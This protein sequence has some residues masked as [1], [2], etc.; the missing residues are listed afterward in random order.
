[1]S[2]RGESMW[3]QQNEAS[4]SRIGCAALIETRGVHQPPNIE[5]IRI[6]DHFTPH[7]EAHEGALGM[8]LTNIPLGEIT[9]DHFQRLIAAQAA[10][11][12]HVEYKRETYGTN[13]DQ[14]REYLAD[15]SSFANSAGGDLVI[16]MIAAKGTPTRVHRF[17]GD[18]D[19]E[20]LR[21]EQMARDGL[22]PRITNLQTRAVGLSGGGF[23]IVVRVPKSYNPPHRI[24]FKNNARFWARSSAGKYE[25]NVE[26]LRRIFSEIPLLA[27]RVRAFRTERTARIAAH[28]TPVG[29]LDGGNLVLHVVPFAAFDFGQSLSLDR[30]AAQPHLFVPIDSRAAQN[31]QIT[32]DGLIT[33]S[34]AEGLS[35]P[36]R[37]YVQ[38][39]RSSAVEAVASSLSRGEETLILPHIEAM[40]VKY[41]RSYAVSLQK[42][43]AE[44]PFAILVSLV[45]IKGK[46]ILQGVSNDP[47][48]GSAVLNHDQYNFV[49]TIFENVPL[50]NNDAAKQLRATLDHLAN[51]AGLPSSPYF[52][53]NG[54]YHI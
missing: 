28:E 15:V 50:D 22:H 29:L 5:A 6:D 46:R 37:A 43:G 48:F 32:F 10:E 1:M 21:L 31:Y 25:P 24:I 13:D 30:V 12:L 9:E 17:E 41:S 45:D 54:D 53:D 18:A 19:A 23:V 8:A 49:E 39:P 35:K 34:N 2:R 11:S 16:G 47:R 42:F 4:I 51:A 3:L 44:P 38:V 26:E 33:T 36:Q 14:R 52:D 27:E 20:R 40:I 7:A